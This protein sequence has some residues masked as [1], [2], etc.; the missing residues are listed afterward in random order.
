MTVLPRIPDH[1]LDDLGPDGRDFGGLRS[2]RGH[3][4]LVAMAVTCDVTGLF[5][6]TRVRQ[7]FVNVL[8]EPIEA[9]YVFP[10]P[11]RAAVSAFSAVLGD[12]RIVGL[13]K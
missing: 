10:L 12:R 1:E 11:D 2:E 7:T 5:V 13:L 3:L 9:T 4:P 8:D 6:T